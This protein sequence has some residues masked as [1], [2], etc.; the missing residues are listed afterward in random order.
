MPTNQPAVTV[1]SPHFDDV[2]LSLGQSLLDGT[3]SHCS[4][5]VRVVFGRSNWTNWVHPTRGRAGAIS[6]WRRGEEELA[7]RSFG[8]RFRFAGWEESILRT[9]EMDEDKVLDAGASLD[10]EPLVDEV[11]AWLTDVV[12]SDRPALLLAPAGIGGHVDHRIVAAAATRLVHESSPPVAFYE[13]RP[14]A[15]HLDHRRLVGQLP[16]PV[17]SLEPIAVSGPITERAQRRARRCYPSQMSSYFA[18]AMA[19]DLVDGACERVWAPT[20][21]A[22]A[23]LA[24]GSEGAS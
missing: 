13:D 14:Y 17:T 16:L 3:L 21:S 11:A 5:Q 8:Y 22:P 7:A 24:S 15:S 10:D 1:L 23:W 2:P 18:D 4:V 12:R 6:W 19:A 20:G 9:G